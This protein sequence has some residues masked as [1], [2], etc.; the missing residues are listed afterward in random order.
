MSGRHLLE[1]APGKVVVRPVLRSPVVARIPG[2]GAAGPS[3]KMRG[4]FR[5]GSPVD[6]GHLAAAQRGWL[7]LADAYWRA[8]RAKP[9]STVADVGSGPAVF[10]ARYADLGGSVTAVDLN[11]EAL[12]LAPRPAGLRTLVHDAELAPLP[13]AY[14]VAFLTDVLHHARAPETLLRNLRASARG[15]VVGELEPSGPGDVGVDPAHR[16]VPAKAAAL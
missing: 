16:L 5:H 9:G 8:S 2:T 14:D 10:A 11:P 6:W 4:H 1:S 13:S 12:E 7:P 3:D 15:L